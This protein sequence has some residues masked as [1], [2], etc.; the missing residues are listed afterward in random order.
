[1]FQCSSL[2]SASAVPWCYLEL[3]PRCKMIVK[4][5]ICNLWSSKVWVLCG[6]GS[7]VSN[8]FGRSQCFECLMLAFTNTGILHGKLS[9]STVCNMLHVALC[10]LSLFKIY[11]RC[12]QNLTE[13]WTSKLL[14]FCFYSLYHSR[15][16]WCSFFSPPSR[17][18]WKMYTVLLLLWGKGG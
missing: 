6:M 13:V 8:Q 9:V 4:S 2:C 10:L 7:F 18:C 12:F 14:R 15:I 5:Y 17:S 1:M 3:I 11:I 16:F